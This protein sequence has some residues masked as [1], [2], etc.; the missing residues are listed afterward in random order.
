MASSDT[1]YHDYRKVTKND[2]IPTQND[3]KASN[4]YFGCCLTYAFTRNLIEL[5]LSLQR[6]MWD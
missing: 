5:S 3:K 6:L 1:N 2:N 4:V